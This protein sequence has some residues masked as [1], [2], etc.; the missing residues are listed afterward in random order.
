MFQFTK[1][2]KALRGNFALSP[3]DI[4]IPFEDVSFYITDLN[5]ETTSM[6]LGTDANELYG[7]LRIISYDFRGINYKIVERVCTIEKYR[8]NGIMK[9]LYS[10]CIELGLKLMSDGTHTTFGSKDFWA[11]GR[12]YFPD[13]SMYVINL[14][15]RYKRLYVNQ[16][17][18][19][20]WGKERDDDF[21][22]L[23]LADKIY[24]LEELRRKEELSSEQFEYF[25]EN[26][27][28]LEDRKHVRL[29]IE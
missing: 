15:S 11:R 27:E 20:I 3:S 4:A 1:E 17:Q 25:S 26:L 18:F 2:I 9:M 12:E 29:T 23:D 24:L 13:K 19:H 7:A 10:H 6:K 14:R 22:V 21:D 5:A 8:K 16:P 28:S